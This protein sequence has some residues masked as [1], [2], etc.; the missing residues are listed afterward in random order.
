ML[1]APA[2]SLAQ[3]RGPRA[4][5]R[6]LPLPPPPAPPRLSSARRCVPIPAP[7]SA[8]A[9]ATSQVTAADEPGASPL[10]SAGGPLPA[11]PARRPLGAA[12][13]NARGGGARTRASPAPRLRRGGWDGR[14]AAAPQLASSRAPLHPHTPARP[15]AE[16]GARAPCTPAGQLRDAP[17][18]AAGVGLGR[19]GCEGRG[20]G[21][22]GGGVCCS[23][24][25][26]PSLQERVCDQLACQR[27]PRPR[28][29]GRFEMSGSVA[30]GPLPVR[31]PLLAAGLL[32]LSQLQ[33]GA[34]WAGNSRSFS[35]K[36]VLRY[37]VEA[38]E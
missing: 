2:R 17:G 22:G 32:N 28:W 3:L 23:R 14:G 38:S 36:A 6:P 25:P 19:E 1:A 13:L 16:P 12:A 20:K 29:A 31:P 30:T 8:G 15:R 18:I 10:Q 37:A 9:P 24:S 27:Q 5:T 33:Q 11:A 4:R 35:L 7:T 21:G 26:A 34:E